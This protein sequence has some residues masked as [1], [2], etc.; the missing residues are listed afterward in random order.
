MHVTYITHYPITLCV[1]RLYGMSF[2]KMFDDCG[3]D[4][5]PQ[6]SVISSVT[7]VF[8]ISIL[9]PVIELIGSSNE[10]KHFETIFVKKETFTNYIKHN[11]RFE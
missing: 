6:G 5:K 9:H 7:D 3:I 4:R 8:K 10:I 1:T 11:S 2:L